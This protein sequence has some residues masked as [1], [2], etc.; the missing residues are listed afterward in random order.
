MAM[1]PEGL[2]LLH[3]SGKLKFE[4]VKQTVSTVKNNFQDYKYSP[5]NVRV[6][7]LYPIGK[8]G[9]WHYA[10]KNKHSY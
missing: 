9:V 1:K 3:L 4:T 7:Y 2:A 10:I 5:K 8:S 6:F